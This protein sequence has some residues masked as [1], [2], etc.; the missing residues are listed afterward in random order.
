[1]TQDIIKCIDI[2]IS[3]AQIITRPSDDNNVAHDNGSCC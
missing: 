1:M 2:M 3:K